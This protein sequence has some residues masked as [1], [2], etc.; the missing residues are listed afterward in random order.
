MSLI[1]F[2]VKLCVYEPY[3]ADSRE[4][5]TDAQGNRVGEL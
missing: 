4:R 5:D 1:S 3:A 2:F